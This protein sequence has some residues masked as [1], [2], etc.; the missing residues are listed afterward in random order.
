MTAPRAKLIPHNPNAVIQTSTGWQYPDGT[1]KAF[2]TR[3][4][5]PIVS[6]P[7]G[8]RRWFR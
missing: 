8:W 4:P 5:A 3:R 7:K 1:F 6:E 2:Y